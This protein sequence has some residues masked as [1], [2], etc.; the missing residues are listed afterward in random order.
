MNWLVHKLV[1]FTVRP[2]RLARVVGLASSAVRDD[3]EIEEL[4]ALINEPFI[5]DLAVFEGGGAEEF[6]RDRVVLLPAEERGVIERWINTDRRLW[7][8]VAVDRGSGITLRDTKTAE[9]LEVTDRT[10]SSE[11]EIGDQLLA[12]AAPGFGRNWLVGVSLRVN[13]RQRPSLVE[14]L[15]AYYDADLLAEWYGRAC[16]HRSWPTGRTSHWCSPP[17]GSVPAKTGGRRSSPT[18]T[19]CTSGRT[20]RRGRRCS[21]WSPVNG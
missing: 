4:I 16:S 19:E 9:E 11:F 18:S 20:K 7:E 8:V 21:K 12:M 13:L 3:F 15:D 5:I 1:R 14:L 17:P 10:A 2:Q 6:L